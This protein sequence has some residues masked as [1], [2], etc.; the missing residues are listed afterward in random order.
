M[1][2]TKK[3]KKNG[4]PANELPAK[5]LSPT[6]K[7]A[8][9]IREARGEKPVPALAKAAGIS[10]PRWYA[11]ERGEVS[12][13]PPIATLWA[14]EKALKVAKDSLASIVYRELKA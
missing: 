9:A 7:L 13:Q 1:T 14:I 11:F 4:R 5:G 6:Q 2:R 8:K 10:A 3:K 12:E